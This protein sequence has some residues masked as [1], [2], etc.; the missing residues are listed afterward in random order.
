MTIDDV[1]LMNLYLEAIDEA[2]LVADEKARGR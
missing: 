2:Q 1:D